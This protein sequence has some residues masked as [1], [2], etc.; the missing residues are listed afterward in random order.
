MNITE[1]ITKLDAADARDKE[2]VIKTNINYKKY[3]PYF[4]KYSICNMCVD[5]FAEQ[6]VSSF[7]VD[8]AAMFPMFVMSAL[9]AHSDLDLNDAERWMADF[10]AMS[11]HGVLDIVMA[12]FAKDFSDMQAMLQL[13]IARKEKMS[14]RAVMDAEA[15]MK[16]IDTVMEAMKIGG[17]NA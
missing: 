2:R 5:K 1:L 3:I 17:Q 16:L 15:L 14:N 6:S 10:D 8:Q 11:E 9:S 12:P 13:C 7:V 4:E